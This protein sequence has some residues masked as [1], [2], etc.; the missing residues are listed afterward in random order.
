VRGRTRRRVIAICVLLSLIFTGYSARLI[1]LQVAR[2]DEFANIAADKHS[3]RQIIPARRGPILDRNG[4]ILAA[5]VPVRKVI[6]DCSHVKKPDQLAEVV[7][8]FI[9][10]KVE[11]V[12]A[13]LKTGKKH[14]VLDQKLPE[15]KAVELRTALDEKNIR[16]IYFEEASERAYS[17]GP[18]LSHVLGFL[19][20]KQPSD[21]TLCG[22]EGIERSM[23]EYLHGEDGVRHIERDRTGKELVIYR[24]QEKPSRQGMSVETTIDMGLQAILEK[25]LET[26]CAE[27]KPDHVVGLIVK[28]QTG[29]ILA[30]ATRPTFDPNNIGASKPED[31]KNRAIIDVIEPGSTF[32]IVAASAALNEGK[33]NQTTQIFCENGAFQYA[34]R[35]L[36]DHHPYG[37][38][39]VREILMKSSN[40]GAAKMALM[41]G[42]QK[43]YEYV[44]RFGF[45]RKTGVELPGEVGGILSPPE[46]WD[47]LTITRMPMG[48]SIAVT[49][50]QSVMSMAAIANGG[51]LMKPLIVRSVKDEDGNVVK[52]FEPEVVAEVVPK[53]VA[54]FVS[55]ALRDVTGDGGTAK[56]ACV[57]GYNVAGKTGTAQKVSPKGGYAPGKYVVSFVG[58]MPAEAPEFAC[59]ILI[60]DAKVASNLNYGGTLAAPVF[61]RVAEKAARYLDLVPSLKAEPVT[62]MVMKENGKKEEFIQ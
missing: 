37:M 29:E 49:P 19:G 33:V 25:E 35:V 54:D 58:Y 5:S 2:H 6:L 51:K 8:P 28:P 61:A 21:V 56:L 44:R 45:G 60:D 3:M 55:S 14:E 48:H 23:E 62:P 18:M 22:V 34:G 27:L 24:E 36:H 53:E 57:N 15:D 32:K 9:G 40:V 12:Q 42:D 4:E 7:A 16:G 39:T 30:M 41:L 43:F 47:K 10:W 50:L 52:S 38:M 17:N 20:R 59:L 31:M 13:R 11:D 1:N 46:R 26:T